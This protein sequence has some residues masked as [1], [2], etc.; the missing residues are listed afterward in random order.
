[1]I[2]CLILLAT[3]MGGIGLGWGVEHYLYHYQ[4]VKCDCHDTTICCA[5]CA[6]TRK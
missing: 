5:G 4:P 1:M 6:C 3:F 2:E